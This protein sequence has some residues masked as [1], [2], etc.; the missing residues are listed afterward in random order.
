M[1]R[2]LPRTIM[3]GLFSVVLAVNT[4]AAE[5]RGIWVDAWGSGFL[6]A[7]E[8]TK[9]VNDCSANN[10]NAVL[11]QMRRRGDAFYMPQLPNL[12]PRTTVLAS[13]YDALAEIIKQCHAAVPRIEVHVWV[14]TFVIWKDQNSPPIQATHVFN[15]H[16]EYL[17]KNSIGT[18]W[19]NEEGYYLDPGNPGATLWNYNMAK[20]I[21]SHYDID[22]FH[23]DYIRYPASDAGY[24]DTAISRYK[25]EFG[26]TSSP[27]PSDAQFS[28]W[29]RRQVTDFLRWVDADLLEIKPKLVLSASVFG[30]RTDAYN[31]RFQDWAGW[32]AEGI[33][34]VSVPM[35]YTSDTTNVF[36]PRVDDQFLNQGVRWIYVGP[37]A[38]LNAPENTVTQLNYVRY[39]GFHGTCFYSYRSPCSDSADLTRVFDY[40]KSNYQ[41]TYT[42]TPSLPWKSSPIAG[43]VKGTATRKDSGSAVY[44]AT[45][46][47]SGSPSKTQKTEPHG[48]YAFFEAAAGTY[49]VSASLSGVGSASANITVSAGGVHTVDLVLSP[50]VQ[51]QTISLRSLA[52][53]DGWVREKKSGAGIGGSLNASSKLLTIGESAAARQYKGIVS[54]DTSGLP[55]GAV[56]QKATLKLTAASTTGS[57]WNTLG[58]LGMAVKSGYFGG[59][60]ALGADDLTAAADVESAGTFA[61][62]PAGKNSILTAELASSALASINKT[63]IT[64][65]RLAFTQPKDSD[66]AADCV[67]IYSGNCK[68][69]VEYQPELVVEYTTP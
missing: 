16:P 14:T 17:M 48:K 42:E 44:N 15:L 6:N 13:D 56:V 2:L 22:G 29:R 1:S 55:D 40:V 69:P 66:K 23:W 26:L 51:V 41:P 62:A 24:N 37:G 32:N 53:H 33:L 21:V 18:T 67:R 3:A 50:D 54:F 8:V 34:D 19:V 5:F 39:K 30:S 27:A 64:Q 28:A 35:T 59:T 65:L 58:A 12:E 60:E 63:G 46:T 52:G 31:A 9:L 49:T 36:I 43:I 11:V 47:L 7:S 61:A 20:D 4:G 57:P 38:Y 25:A 68:K 10:F 45:V